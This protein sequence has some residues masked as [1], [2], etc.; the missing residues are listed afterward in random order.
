MT[1][2]ISDGRRTWNNNRITFTPRVNLYR[3]SRKC[4]AA[5]LHAIHQQ[6]C[7]SHSSP[8]LPPRDSLASPAEHYV[9]PRLRSR[10]Q[11]V[12]HCRGARPRSVWCRREREAARRWRLPRLPKN[13]ACSS[14]FGICGSSPISCSGYSFSDGL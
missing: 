13:Q 12:Y 8:H 3:R 14:A 10:L 9:W 6:H 11:L 7:F 1:D 2:Y 4:T 5:S